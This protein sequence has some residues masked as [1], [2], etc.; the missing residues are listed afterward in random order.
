MK[1]KVIILILLM[2]IIASVSSFAFGIGGAFAFEPFGGTRAY[3][4]GALSFKIND[5]PLIA[6]QASG[7][8]GIFNIG[9]TADWWMYHEPLVGILSLYAGPG[10]YGYASIGNNVNFD[11]GL[12]V[13][14]G[15]Q[16]FPI[17]P[18]ELFLEAAP[19][20]GVT[21]GDN[22]DF[23]RFGLQSAVGFRFWF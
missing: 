17:E 23:P 21:L 10:G 16:I 7:S 18:L 22:F 1:N 6:I 4:G 15:L 11:L 3:N 2:L 19:S 5:W 12:R 8:D 14:I 20:F 9:A 13:P